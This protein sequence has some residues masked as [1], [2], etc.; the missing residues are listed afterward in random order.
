MSTR[1]REDAPDLLME[2][3]CALLTDPFY[4]VHMAAVSALRS[5]RPPET[6]AQR[7]RAGLVQVFHWHMTD[8]KHDSVVL[9]CARMLAVRHFSEAECSGPAGAT[10]IRVLRRLKPM[11]LSDDL[12]TFVGKLGR[13]EG[14]LDLLVD[15]LK[16]PD[17]S[18]HSQDKI[19]DALAR[20]PVDV[21]YA[22]RAALA[23][24]PIRS[25]WEDRRTVLEIA[26]ILS[27]VDAWAEAEALSARILD[28]VPETTWEAQARQHFGRAQIVVSF[29]A[30]LARGDL[31][32]ARA[33][34]AVWR[35]DPGA[36]A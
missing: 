24:L 34:M 17:V 32:A 27:R 25:T 2:A 12:R 36:A 6:Y 8:E 22:G 16:D 30:A 18:E 11:R 13:A 31:A 23:D 19:V 28:S 4:M 10:L 5:F 15:L 1:E 29:E 20:M 3:F 9:D 14:M 7:V 35:E 26:E 33:Q 21:V